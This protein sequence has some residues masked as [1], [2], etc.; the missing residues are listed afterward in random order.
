MES[1][2]I[3][4]VRPRRDWLL[5]L[6][7]ARRDKTAS[8]LLLPGH[9]TGVEKVTEGAGLV[10]SVGPGEKNRVLGLEKGV[11]IVFRSFI[12]HANR[13]PVEESWDSGEQKIYFLMSSDDAIGVMA[14]GVDVGVFSGRPE[15]PAKE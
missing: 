2:D 4:K 5:V 11:R 15:V 1:A 10:I 14:P 3:S 7:D 8:G 9:E 13:L 12:K 6:A